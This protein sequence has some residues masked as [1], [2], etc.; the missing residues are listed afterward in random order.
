MTSE[1]QRS[2]TAEPVIAIFVIPDISSKLLTFVSA[3]GLICIHPIIIFRVFLSRDS[4]FC[5]RSSSNFYFHKRLFSATFNLFSNFLFFFFFFSFF[6][7]IVIHCWLHII[8]MFSAETKKNVCLSFY[9][10]SKIILF[11]HWLC[12]FITRRYY[13]LQIGWWIIWWW[14]LRWIFSRCS[15]DME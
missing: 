6:E 9:L 3:P 14:R 10:F 7:F 4:I 11:W 12:F 5:F 13:L 2:C 8:F 15:D 1:H